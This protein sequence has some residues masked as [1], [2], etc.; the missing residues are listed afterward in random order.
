MNL[1][2]VIFHGPSGSGKDTQLDL[3]AKEIGFVRI[4]SSDVMRD[5][6]SEEHEL[7]KIADEYGKQ[8][9]L[10]PDEIIYGMLDVWLKRL[11]PDSRWFFVSPVRRS[12][13][14]NLFEELISKHWRKLDL[15]VHFQLSEEAAIERM[16]NRRFCP[17]CNTTYHKLYKKEEKEGYC[18]NDNEK[19][20]QRDD[21]KPEAIKTRLSWYNDDIEPILEEYDKRGLLLNIDASPSI[22]EIHE[23]LIGEI[24]K[25]G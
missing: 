25:Y 14:I 4:G 12:T 11:D 18:N 15:F 2:T 24:K 10:Y 21:D 22:N 5:L 23:T 8:G 16:S 1:K 3:L 17:S 9:K 20:I 6:R 13:Q 19:L 7:A